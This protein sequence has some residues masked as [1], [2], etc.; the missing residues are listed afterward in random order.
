MKDLNLHHSIVK[1][2]YGAAFKLIYEDNLKDL[3]A[4]TQK[5]LCDMT[6][7][8]IVVED[9]I[10]EFSIL[11]KLPEEFHSLM[12]KVT[13]SSDTQGNPDAILNLLHEAYPKEEFHPAQPNI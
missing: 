11:T 5:C 6:S 3:I 8:G 1:L 9:K 4:N 7:I 13:L 2:E 12:E 10:L